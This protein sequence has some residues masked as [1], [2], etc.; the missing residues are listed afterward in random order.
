[1]FSPTESRYLETVLSQLKDE[2]VDLI[3]VPDIYEYVALGQA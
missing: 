2:I 1:M 3:L